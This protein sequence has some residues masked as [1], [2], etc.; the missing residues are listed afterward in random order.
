MRSKGAG[1]SGSSAEIGGGSLVMMA[2]IKLA[3]LFPSNAFVPVS[4]S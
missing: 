4:I 3:W 2:P 1:L